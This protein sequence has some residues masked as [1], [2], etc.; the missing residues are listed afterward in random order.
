MGTQTAASGR[1]RRSSWYVFDLRFSTGQS[2]PGAGSCHEIMRV[3][4]CDFS[5][6]LSL[7]ASATTGQG[8]FLGLLLA[9]RSLQS[10]PIQRM[11]KIKTI[12]N[13]ELK[14]TNCR[15]KKE[16][17]WSHFSVF[18]RTALTLSSSFWWLYKPCHHEP[19]TYSLLPLFSL[20]DQFKLTNIYRLFSD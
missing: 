5:L 18:I 17:L 16:K 7:E 2:Q 14:R 1:H 11:L 10:L 4:R 15:R 9:L 13:G 20:S 12:I 3:G 8:S 19:Y 6:S